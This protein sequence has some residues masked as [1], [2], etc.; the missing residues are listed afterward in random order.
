MPADLLHNTLHIKHGSRGI[1]GKRLPRWE[2]RIRNSRRGN[3][4]FVFSP[5]LRIKNNLFRAT[6][7][8]GCFTVLVPVR[9]CWTFITIF[10]KSAS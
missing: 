4:S 9:K 7:P 10:D 6:I 2:G 5:P 8:I 3:T 1:R